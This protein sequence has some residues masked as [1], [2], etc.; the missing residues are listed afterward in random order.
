MDPLYT[1]GLPLSIAAGIAIVAPAG[2]AAAQAK[3]YFMSAQ[4]AIDEIA[5]LSCDVN[6]YMLGTD[7]EKFA[8]SV[9][10]TASI[11]AA[12]TDDG[13]GRLIK[14]EMGAFLGR[15]AT[16]F[17]VFRNGL[18]DVSFIDND[19]SKLI[20]ASSRPGQPV[21]NAAP[22]SNADQAA[23]NNFFGE[24]YIALSSKSAV[25]ENPRKVDG[26][27]C[28][29][30]LVT[31]GTERTRWL[32]GQD[33]R[34]PRRIEELA[35]ELPEGAETGDFNYSMKVFEISNIKI[36]ETFTVDELRLVA[37]SG[38]TTEY[39]GRRSREAPG[40]DGRDTNPQGGHSMPPENPLAVPDTLKVGTEKGNI[41]PAIRLKTIDGEDITLGDFRG[42]NVIL[43]FWS[44]WAPKTSTAS[45]EISDLVERM[46]GGVE[47]LSV[48][49]KE[50]IP[51]AAAEK[52]DAEGHDFVLAI[53]DDR[54]ARDYEV[55]RVPAIFVIN[56]KGR[57]LLEAR[58]YEE[59]ET[60]KLVEEALT[61]GDE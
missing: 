47:V 2:T 16:P 14:G 11:K 39:R 25:I 52:L 1:R 35:P 26:V 55:R 32:I 37:P 17:T 9:D 45:A 54:A 40:Y 4:A 6:T 28:D 53:D 59:G 60:I 22:V 61:S 44:T 41:A 36:N 5:T 30:I 34:I 46:D 18:F 58:E 23:L 42:E 57:I 49:F 7:G 10:V 38:Y 24:G 31:D 50:R 43:Y 56:E 19:A 8:Y 12:R 29:S 27:M 48:A 13:W 20:Y 3:D 51:T 33:D 15:P 21:R